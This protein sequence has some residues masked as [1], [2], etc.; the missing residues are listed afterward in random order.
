MK[1]DSK[2]QSLL[3]FCPKKL[4]LKQIINTVRSLT[5]GDQAI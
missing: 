3:H 2:N 5:K 4:A 1:C